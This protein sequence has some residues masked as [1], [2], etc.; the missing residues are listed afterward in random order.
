MSFL[1][2]LNKKFVNLAERRK[3]IRKVILVQQILISP[4]YKFYMY[5]ITTFI[6]FLA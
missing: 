2:F 3:R 1:L 6:F 5:L 4:K